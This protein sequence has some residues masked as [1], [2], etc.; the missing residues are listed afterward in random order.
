MKKE[1]IDDLENDMW[2]EL[3]IPCG[4]YKSEITC[5]ILIHLRD[6]IIA[7]ETGGHPIFA[8]NKYLELIKCILCNEDRMDYSISP[9]WAWIE[10]PGI[11]F[12]NKYKAVL[13]FYESEEDE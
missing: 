9:R 8:D 7:K 5:D 6:S 3:G 2:D 13:E 1:E 10:Q 12:Y 11:D 4:A